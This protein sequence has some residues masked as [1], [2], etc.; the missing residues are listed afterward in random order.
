MRMLRKWKSIREENLIDVDSILDLSEE[1]A[2]FMHHD[3]ITG[4]AK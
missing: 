2:L 4:T 1:T 3:S